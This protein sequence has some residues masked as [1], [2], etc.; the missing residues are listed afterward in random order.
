MRFRDLKLRTKQFVGFGL[1]LLLMGVVGFLTVERMESIQDNLNRI[2]GYWMPQALELSDIESDALALHNSQ[3]LFAMAERDEERMVYAE[4]MTTLIDAINERYDAALLLDEA[5]LNDDIVVQTDSAFNERLEQQWEAYLDLTDTF[6]DL[7]L[8][9]QREEAVALLNGDLRTTFEQTRSTLNTLVQ[10]GRSAATEAALEGNRTYQDTRTLA[11]NLLLVSLL[12]SALLSYGLVQLITNPIQKLDTAAGLVAEGDL[13]VE[14]PVE[15]QDEVG[16]LTSSFNRMTAALREAWEKNTR[17][18]AEL[19]RVNAALAGQN[20]EIERQHA[21]L[22]VAH[23][24]LQDAQQKLVQSEKMASVGQLTAGIAHEINNPINFV[25]SNVQPLKQD[26]DDV[27]EI[28]DTY[29][30]TVAQHALGE[31]FNDVDALKEDVDYDFVRDEINDLLNGIE[32]GAKRTAEIVKGL[33]NFSR[34]DE[35]EQKMANVN[36]GLESTLMLLRNTLKHRIEV[37]KDF[38]DVPDIRCYP[39][40]LNQVFMNL[41]VNAEQAIEG[42]G[43]IFITTRAEAE[44]VA[45]SIRDTGKGIAPDALQRI[46][47]PFYTTKAVGSGTGLGLSIVYGIIEDHDGSI[48]AESTVGEGAEFIITLPITA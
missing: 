48:V 12:V 34:L 2:T 16:H 9:D 23:G 3:L 5:A 32:E 40:K 24:Q 20:A 38:G 35:A 36:Q 8:D 25:S 21:D 46:F 29:D 31:T 11:R 43:Q 39:G 27:F 45:I 13:E 6:I 7:S 41:L 14:L 47:E 17:Q 26:L 44:A 30:T 4:Q 18:Q 37:V 33:R 10:A 28:L 15:S 1:V 19:Q 22:E 42:E